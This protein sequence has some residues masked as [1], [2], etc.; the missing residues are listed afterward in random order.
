VEKDWE[1]RFTVP[2]SMDRR[3][4]VF[5]LVLFAILCLPLLFPVYIFLLVG[6]LPAVSASFIMRRLGRR[7]LTTRGIAAIAIRLGNS[8][9]MVGGCLG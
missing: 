8:V 7:P 5:V 1:A 9:G 3:A 2:P 4:I 6:F